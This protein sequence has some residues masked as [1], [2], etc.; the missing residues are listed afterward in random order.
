MKKIQAIVFTLILTCLFS[1]T[2]DAQFAVLYR[3]QVGTFTCAE[4]YIICLGSQFPGRFGWRLDMTWKYCP[5]DVG[6]DSCT[7]VPSVR[8][9]RVHGCEFTDYAC[10]LQFGPGQ[11]YTRIFCNECSGD[12]DMEDN[13]CVGC[14][15][16]CP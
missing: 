12:T 7:Y 15:I 11:G 8:T 16:N 3:C 6:D 10:G 14:N 13:I 5:P 1:V 2:V 4:T 9:C